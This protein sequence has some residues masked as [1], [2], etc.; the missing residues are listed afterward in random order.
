[1]SMPALS[2]LDQSFLDVFPNEIILQI[3]SFCDIST[4]AALCRV[5][6]LFQQLSVPG[7]YRTV[8]LDDDGLPRNTTKTTIYLFAISVSIS[9]HQQYTTFLSIKTNH[10]RQEETENAI[11]C[12]LLKTTGL[13][14]LH[15]NRHWI[16]DFHLPPAFE[17]LSFPHLH[18]VDFGSSQTGIQWSQEGPLLGS[19]I[20]RHPSISHLA[21]PRTPLGPP[22]AQLTPINLP[23]LI[24][25]S[26]PITSLDRLKNTDKL[27]SVKLDV[28][29]NNSEWDVLACF[30]ACQDVH[31]IF[32]EPMEEVEEIRDM[33][34]MLKQ[35][36]PDLKSLSLIHTG[37]C[38]RARVRELLES[39][40][41]EELVGFNQLE[42]FGFGANLF[43]E[44]N[45]PDFHS[46]IITSW[47]EACPTLQAVSIFLRGWD[48]PEGRY[49]IVDEKAEPTSEPCRLEKLFTHTN[50]LATEHITS[51]Q[52]NFQ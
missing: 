15:L 19:F 14:G 23:N 30:P 36:F 17:T 28:N 4:Q 43:D 16:G 31:L 37:F 29:S 24:L 25:Y 7:L 33:F 40:L 1:M 18:I 39:M 32:P 38:L 47:I 5:C 11:N 10:I 45:H 42:S 41:A 21:L 9:R 22:S 12:I 50:W 46:P 35:L 49:K 34:R 6:R 2:V 13:R 20:N 26:G 51:T 44:M 52:Y 48:D 3:I 27:Q 8:E